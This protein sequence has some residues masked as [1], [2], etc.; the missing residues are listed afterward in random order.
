[1]LT[2]IAETGHVKMLILK[3]QAS[4]TMVAYSLES[5]L[6]RKKFL[7]R[8]LI[9][10]CIRNVLFNQALRKKFQY[11][12]LFLSLPLTSDKTFFLY[13][14]IIFHFLPSNLHKNLYNYV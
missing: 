7:E 4:F 14:N 10:R 8:S 9:L 12:P 5:I 3:T 11:K 2:C 6:K 1:M 13:T